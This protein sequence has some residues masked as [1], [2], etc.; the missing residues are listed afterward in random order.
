LNDRYA[1][2]GAQATATFLGALTKG[3]EEWEKEK[4]ALRDLNSDATAICTTDGE[5]N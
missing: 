1:V 2:S 3:W 5:C 4:P